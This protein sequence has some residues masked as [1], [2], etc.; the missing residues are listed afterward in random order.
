MSCRSSTARLNADVKVKRIDGFL[1]DGADRD[2]VR[3][4]AFRRSHRVA[5]ADRV[6]PN[7]V[8]GGWTGTVNLKLASLVLENGWPTPRKATSKPST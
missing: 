2:A 3:S 6:A 7:A 1:A 8:R 5:A 4:T